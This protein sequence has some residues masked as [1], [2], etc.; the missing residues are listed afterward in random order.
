MATF[1][2]QVITPER[3]FID[4]EAEMLILR[5][6]DGEIGIG[7]G[8]VPVIISLEDGELRVKM[9]GQWRTAAGGEGTA[10]VTPDQVFVMM[11]SIEWPEEIDARRAEEARARAEE[12]MRQKCSMQE[13]VMA[14]S[15]LSRA[16]TRLRVA[17]N[18]SQND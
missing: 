12:I 13:Y 2:L 1:H 7:A 4:G 17:R 6:P 3:V 5:A 15:M 8:H 14:Q 10:T 11:Q 9:N 18:V 16:M